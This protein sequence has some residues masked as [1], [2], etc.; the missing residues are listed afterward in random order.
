MGIVHTSVT[1]EI[2][3]KWRNTLKQ[4]AKPNI[5][6]YTRGM[7]RNPNSTSNSSDQNILKSLSATTLLQEGKFRK[8]GSLSTL[9]G[10]KERN[11][12][13][14]SNGVIKFPAHTEKSYLNV[15]YVIVKISDIAQVDVS[16]SADY[17]LELGKLR[18][19]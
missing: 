1:T 6:I 15:E 16:G 7:N 3:A 4:S 14:H 9:S 5:T 13:L 17:S 18:Y 2:T 12:S 11:F 8:H 10:W 19:S